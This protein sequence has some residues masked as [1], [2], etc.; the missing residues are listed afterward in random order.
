V[1]TNGEGVD[2]ASAISLLGPDTLDARAR[3]LVVYDSPAADR[4][5]WPDTVLADRVRIGLEGAA[6]LDGAVG[7]AV[8]DDLAAPHGLAPADVAVVGPAAT[9]VH[10]LDENDTDDD[11][12]DD[13]LD[14]EFADDPSDDEPVAAP[15][16]PVAAEPAEPAPVDEPSATVL[17]PNNLRQFGT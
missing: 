13:S 17:F 12:L 8:G 11:E 14:E 15:D 5:P 6:E 10:P 9:D 3:L 1:V 2:H 7:D 4:R 16:H